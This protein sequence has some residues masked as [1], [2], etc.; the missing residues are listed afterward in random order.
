MMFFD[1][2]LHGNLRPIPNPHDDYGTWPF[3]YFCYLQ[4]ITVMMGMMVVVVMMMTHYNIMLIL[5][6]IS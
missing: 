5:S 2:F 3:N 4:L 6:I 1:R